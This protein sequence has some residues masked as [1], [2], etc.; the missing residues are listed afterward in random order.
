MFLVSDV[1]CNSLGDLA[2]KSAVCGCYSR[3]IVD[4]CQV[5]TAILASIETGSVVTLEKLLLS[6]AQR[7]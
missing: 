5:S 6:A 2:R 7:E 1:F 4:M 3:K